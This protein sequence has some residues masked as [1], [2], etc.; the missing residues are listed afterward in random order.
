MWAYL[1]HCDLTYSS[2]N[3]VW[4]HLFIQL[5]WYALSVFFQYLKTTHTCIRHFRLLK[6]ILFVVLYTNLHHRR[7]LSSLV[8]IQRHRNH[9]HGYNRCTCHDICEHNPAQKVRVSKLK[10]QLK[11]YWNKIHKYKYHIWYS[12]I[13][14][15]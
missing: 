8:D 6:R 5:F 14:H 4:R 9:W 10:V 1:V 7:F 11:S 3:I 15:I 13:C 12:I 2:S